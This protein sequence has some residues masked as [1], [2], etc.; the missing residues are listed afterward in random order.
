M[1]ISLEED[2]RNP[3][4][5]ILLTGMDPIS[6]NWGKCIEY[7]PFGGNAILLNDDRVDLS[8]ELVQ[9]ITAYSLEVLKPLFEKSLKGGIS[10]QDVLADI[11]P[12][13]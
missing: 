13:R 3:Y 12:E 2:F 8:F 1:D 9:T 7:S 5:D 11:L 10:R 4:A 6:E